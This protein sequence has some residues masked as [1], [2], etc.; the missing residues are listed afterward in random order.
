LLSTLS[1]LSG[2]FARFALSPSPFSTIDVADLR[3]RHQLQGLIEL[4][5]YRLFTEQGTLQVHA[6]YAYSQVDA[7]CCCCCS[8][9]TGYCSAMLLPQWRK[10]GGFRKALLVSKGFCLLSGYLG[11][12]G[13]WSLPPTGRQPV[14]QIQLYRQGLESRRLCVEHVHYQ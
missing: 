7:R 3:S 8:C 4:F 9:D 10:G 5:W 14:R 6:H 12:F 2:L 13:Q 11:M 1:I